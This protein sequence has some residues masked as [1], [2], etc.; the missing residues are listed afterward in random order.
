MMEIYSALNE[1]D[2]FSGLE[3]LIISEKLQEKL[4]I[5]KKSGTWAEVWTICEEG[6]ELEPSSVPTSEQLGSSQ[7][8][9]LHV[10]LADSSYSGRRI[11]NTV[12]CVPKNM[13]RERCSSSMEARKVGFDGKIS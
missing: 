12:P 1:L 2:G 13:V 5:S 6:L 7:L 9:S 4:L 10:Q 8:S 11:I 3:S